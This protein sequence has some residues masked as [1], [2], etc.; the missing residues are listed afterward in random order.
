MNK[1]TGLLI[2]CFLAL[3]SCNK[4]ASRKLQLAAS[5]LE[6]RAD[7]ALIIL[8]GIDTSS[9]ITQSKK[10]QYALY[11][12]AALDKNYIDV[13]S[14]SLIRVAV[15]YYSLHGKPDKRMMTWYYQGIIQKNKGLYPQSVVS[16][17]KAANY[18]E[19]LHDYHYLGLINRNIASAFSLSNNIVSAIDYRERA[20]DCFSKTASDS[21]Y[22]YYAQYAL[23]NEYYVNKDYKLARRAVADLSGVNIKSIRNA[24]VLLSARIALETD[25]DARMAIASFRSVPPRAM[26]FM[27][28]AQLAY[29]YDL[30]EETDSC[31]K[32]IDIGYSRA[33]KEEDSSTIDYIVSQIKMRRKEYAEAWHLMNHAS[34]IQDS[35]TRAMLTESLCS[36]QRDYFKEVSNSQ[37]QSIAEARLR[38][39][40]IG[41]SGF[42]LAITM[43][44]LLV[45]RGRRKDQLIKETMAKLILIDKSNSELSKSNAQL[46]AAH[47]SERIRLL[48]QL[49]RDYYYADN[50]DK[51]DLVFQQFKIY[52]KKLESDDSFYSSLEDDLNLY[53]D[54]I[55]IKLKKE[56]P[57]IKGSNLRLIELFFAGFNYETIA[58]ITHAQSIGSLKTKKSRLRKY[59]EQSQSENIP[60]FLD[61][62]EMKRPQA[63]KTGITNPGES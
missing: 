43:I 14:D 28:C 40:I 51:K 18:A 60:F 50:N 6:R 42:L 57:E 37:K 24:C 36:A 38:T 46:V 27:D 44:V 56:V 20:V 15:K 41:L 5:L 55:M 30:L 62:L 4:T 34:Q 32:W 21:L 12:S 29:A 54:S 23:A 48:D 59:I 33:L 49:S 31:N 61:M 10:A 47:Y 11:K 17:E 13:D 19:S 3:V 25:S 45:L 26:S 63:K 16:F 2:I 35:L 52:L 9:L 53:C 39:L 8:N 7:S 58:L 22:L 1:R